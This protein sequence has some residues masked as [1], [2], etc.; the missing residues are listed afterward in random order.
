MDVH[1]N[2]VLKLESEAAAGGKMFFFE[3]Q[4]TAVILCQVSS[5]HCVHLQCNVCMLPLVW[6]RKFRRLKTHKQ[7]I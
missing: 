5:H 1:G 2:N 6:E 4:S 3:S 7:Q